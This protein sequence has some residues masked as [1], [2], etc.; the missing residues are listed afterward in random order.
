MNSTSADAIRLVCQNITNP[1]TLDFS[2]D[3]LASGCVGGGVASEDEGGEG[4]T[5]VGGAGEGGAGVGG[6][7]QL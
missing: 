7:A 6:G 1:E 4:G 2:T 5:G 3:K